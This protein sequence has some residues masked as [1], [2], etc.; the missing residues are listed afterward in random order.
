MA[1]AIRFKEM[2]RVLNERAE[3]LVDWR[4]GG[5]HTKYKL[6]DGV[7]SGFAM[8]YMQS[9]SFLAYQRDMQRKKGKNNARSLFGVKEIPSDGQIR[10]LLDALK[11]EEIG[12]SFW[13]IMEM[14]E[15]AGH[16][17]R[18]QTWRGQVLVSLDGTQYFSSTK[19]H[20]PQCTVWQRESGVRYSHT[21]L[22]PVVV[23]PGQ[24]QV[25][26]LEPEYILPQDGQEKQDCEQN[27]AKRWVERQ[28]ERLSRWSV[29]MLADDLHA[30]QPFC[31]LLR[32]KGIH[33]ILT[34]W[35]QTHETLYQEVNLL[36]QIGGV[37]EVTE[38]KWNGRSHE[39]W[40][41]RYA[42]EVPLRSG[43]DALKVNW[44]EFRI[45]VEETGEVL[46]H[47]AF[48]TDFALDEHTVV[49]V[50][51]AGRSRWK[52][53]NENNN[54]LKNQGYHLEHNYGHGKQHLAS[55]LLSL[56]LLAFLFHTVLS[57]SDEVYQAV[58]Q[59]LGRRTTFF[60]DLLALTRYLYFPDWDTLLDFMYKGL[61]I[62]PT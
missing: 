22:T 12:L 32:N 45:V 46:Y 17:E 43:A 52:V 14:V 9:P 34:C 33:F 58:R 19:I 24:A 29:T 54:V 28:A 59:E 51:A 62:A 27:A 3:A 60:H 40:T 35:P 48:I 41:Y 8:F 42:S 61:D 36:A 4:Q 1:E 6:A 47:N 23:A 13:E 50:V 26:C 7:L 18:L 44:C 56:N 53:E 31:L 39:R 5:N 55:F 37:G 11:P 21:V 20:C 57:L 15:R 16:L 25:L 2:L 49:E 38:R 30:H 10:N